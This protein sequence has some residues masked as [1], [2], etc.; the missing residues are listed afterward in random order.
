MRRKRSSSYYHWLYFRGPFRLITLHAMY[1]PGLFGFVGIVICMATETVAFLLPSIVCIGI[2]YWVFRIRQS[3]DNQ[4]L[5]SAPDEDLLI[6]RQGSV[7]KGRIGNNQ[8]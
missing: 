6:V 1:W 3:Y 2:S 7:A 8:R 4:L 5:N